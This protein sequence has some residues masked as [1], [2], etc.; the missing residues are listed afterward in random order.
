MAACLSL[1]LLFAACGPGAVDAAFGGGTVALEPGSV[2]VAVL[3]VAGGGVVATGRSDRLLTN[4]DVSGRVHNDWGAA[5]AA[6]L[7][8]GI[9]LSKVPT[10]ILAAGRDSTGYARLIHVPDDGTRAWGFVG[11]SAVVSPSPV[12]G[13]GAVPLTSGQILALAGVVTTPETALTPKIDVLRFT[14]SGELVATTRYDVAVGDPPGGSFD[15]TVASVVATARGTVAAVGWSWKNG[16]LPAPG[17]S[18]RM[19]YLYR[20]RDDGTLDPTWGGASQ[21]G[22]GTLPL[23]GSIAGA[24]VTWT[25]ANR[26]AA[27]PDGRVAAIGLMDALVPIDDVDPTAQRVDRYYFLRIFEADG[28]PALAFHGT[29]VKIW[30]ASVANEA[31]EPTTLI[32]N[33]SGT[34]LFVAGLRGEGKAG[35]VASFDVGSSELDTTFG[36]RGYAAVPGVPSSLARDVTSARL[37]VASQQGGR[38]QVTRLVID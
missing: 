7:V 19:S 16:D 4:I 18:A 8:S 12:N 1:S 26:V 25:V 21:G 36:Y 2:E 32:S 30:P 33:A 31:F 20:F 23:G 22:P 9:T 15:V 6:A 24:I 10:G 38:A 27:L 34:R 3:G 5:H 13:F 17:V 29:G 11:G 28:S 35:V 14:S 37:Y